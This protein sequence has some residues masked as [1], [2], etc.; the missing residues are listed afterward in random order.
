MIYINDM[1][2]AVQSIAKMFADDTKLFARSDAV[3]DMTAT[4]KDLDSLCDC[5]E[6]LQLLFHPQKC[7]VLK[8]G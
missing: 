6:D 4:Q 7:E 2:T 1:P 3:A 5:S 8:L